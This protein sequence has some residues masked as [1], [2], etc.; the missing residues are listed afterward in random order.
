MA[1]IYIHVPYCRAACHY[2]NF[3]FSTQLDTIPKYLSALKT[4]IKLRQNTLSTLSIESVYLGG[5]TPTVLS[6]QQIDSIYKTLARYVSLDRV[7]EYTLEANPEDLSTEY[8]RAL[9]D[10]PVD[11]ISLGVQSLDTA[12]LQWMNRGHTGPQALTVLQ[13]LRAEG[14]Q[15]ISA[16]LIFGYQGLTPQQWCSELQTFI[17]MQIPHISHYGLTIE[18]RTYFGHVESKGQV[19]TSEAMPEQMM[20]LYQRLETAGYT[21]YELSNSALPG[22]EAVHNAGYWKGLP[23]LGLGPAAH[24]YDGHRTRYL[25]IENSPLYIKS[26]DDKKLNQQIETLTDADY[27]HEFLMLRLRTREGILWDDFIEKFGVSARQKLQNKMRVLDSRWY[28]S[29]SKGMRLT[30]EGWVWSDFIFR[31]IFD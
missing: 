16:D 6:P 11:R 17:D 5:G 3:H 12:T 23:Y 15:N 28:V 8:I 10:T 1:G 14:Y 27:Y 29:T 21:H 20:E 2:C 30:Y 18:S 9:R 26:L 13:N 4:E 22:Y 19:L 31:E 24:G 25:N 7:R